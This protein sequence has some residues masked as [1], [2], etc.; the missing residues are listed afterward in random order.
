MLKYLCISP[1]MY[2]FAAEMKRFGHI[3]LSVLLS[4]SILL[5]GSGI[6]I[7][8]CSHTGT[9]KVMTA[10][11]DNRMSDMDGMDCSMTS[12]CMTVTHLELSPTIT[13][14]TTSID[15]HVLQPVLAVLPSL[16]LECL[17][18]TA[19]KATVQPRQEVWKSPP[20]AYLNLI[21]VLLI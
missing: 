1:E 21:Q 13:A 8:R 7:T 11:G 6:S 16:A 14:Q 10:I 2:N 17:Q 4:V 12:K 9:V 20:R 18:P 19:C 5:I 3:I 15:F